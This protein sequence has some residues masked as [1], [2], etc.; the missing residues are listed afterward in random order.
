MKSDKKYSSVHQYL[1][2][3]FA[4]IDHPTD[5]EIKEAKSKYRKLYLEAYQK[6]RRERIKEFTLGFDAYHIKL[7]HKERGKLNVSEFLY[8]CVYTALN[9]QGV[10]DTKL[11]GRIHALQLEIINALE[12]MLEHTDSYIMEVFLEKMEALETQIIQLKE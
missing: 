8:Q 9:D 2:A 5:K 1:D 6:N 12:D 10:F 7:I 3:V 4:H 11:L